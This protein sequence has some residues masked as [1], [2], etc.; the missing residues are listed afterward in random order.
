[1]Q[2]DV[3][4]ELDANGILNVS[5]VDVNTKAKANITIANSKG[6]LSSDEVGKMV[7][8]AE[9]LAKDDAERLARTE[10]KNELEAALYQASEVAASALASALS[11][12][13]KD[14]ATRLE[15]VVRALKAW[16]EIAPEN[17]PVSTFNDKMRE[18]QL[19]VA[20]A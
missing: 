13:A 15:E 20:T 5:A 17:T 3:T 10:A 1:M 9:R 2:I 11:A 7:A 14:K 4:F 18:L 19:A 12:K 16:V 6:R 8:E